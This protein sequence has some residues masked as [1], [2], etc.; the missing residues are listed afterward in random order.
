MNLQ[1]LRSQVKAGKID[2][3]IV[4]FPDVFGRLMG[5]RFTGQSSSIP[6]RTTARTAATISSR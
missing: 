6:L 5:K 3:V 1:T 4:A 2:T